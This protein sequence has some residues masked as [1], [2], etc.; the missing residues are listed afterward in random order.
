MII[1]CTECKKLYKD[2]DIVCLTKSSLAGVNLVPLCKA[3]VKKFKK[4]SGEK[5]DEVKI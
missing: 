1:Q 2:E 3:C 5:P 4:D